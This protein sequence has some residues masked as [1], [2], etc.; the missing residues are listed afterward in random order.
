M[1]GR[2]SPTDRGQAYTLE[3]FIGAIVVLTA[4]LFAL[5]AIVITPTTGGSVDRTVQSQLQQ[6]AQDSLVLA[7]N[8]GELS[9]LIRY[10]DDDD[11][12]FYNADDSPGPAP[13]SYGRFA[14]SSAMDAQFGAVLR[15]RFHDSGRYY[16]V[17]LVYRTDDGPESEYLVYQG[18]PSSNAFTASYA[19]ALYDDQPLTSTERGNATLSSADSYP[20]PD[21]DEGSELYNVVE[22]RIVVW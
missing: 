20:I 22:V 18:G 3:G 10:W 19:V 16:N 21:V 14:N 12:S 1:S 2:S 13:Y 6:Q 4:V 15:E 9:H 5:Q 17:E 8:D 7:E 11:E